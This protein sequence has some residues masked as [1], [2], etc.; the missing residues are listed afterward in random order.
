MPR[1]AELTGCALLAI[2]ATLAL[3]GPAA[4]EGKPAPVVEL[5]SRASGSDGAKATLRSQ[6]PT[7]SDDGNLVAFDTQSQLV[8]EDQD[9]FQ[10]VYVRDREAQQTILVS[11]QNGV[12]GPKA[13][14]HSG[15]SMI[16]GNGRFVVFSS[17][18]AANLGGAGGNLYLRDLSANTTTPISPINPATGAPVSGSA[19]SISADGTRVAFVVTEPGLDPADT[20][21]DREVYVRDLTTGETVLASRQSGPSGASANSSANEPAIS[22]DGRSVAFTLN[23]GYSNLDPDPHGEEA[24][25]TYVRDL[26]TLTTTLLSRASGK[27]G[28]WGGSHN[29]DLSFDG[30]RAVFEGDQDLDP[31]FPEFVSGSAVLVRDLETFETKAM[32]RKLSPP[33]DSEVVDSLSSSISASGQR[34]TFDV[35]LRTGLRHKA[36]V[37]SASFTRAKT[38]PVPG[39]RS[40]GVEGTP[41][42]LASTLSGDGRWVAFRSDARNLVPDDGDIVQDI[43]VARVRK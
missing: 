27:K 29:A 43:F 34:T 21:D 17:N 42:D 38:N 8:P 22:G 24:N 26:E 19:P 14:D 4:A 12:D 15:Q 13:N 3:S 37:Y 32:N 10:D 5:V 39:A 40:R 35:D 31:P 2:A 7:I 11:R 23:S 30:D 41:L 28:H 18:R 20:F 25:T 9:T 36:Q 33:N 16:S 1:L 6:E